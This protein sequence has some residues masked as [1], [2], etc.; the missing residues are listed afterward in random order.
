LPIRNYN[1][2][3]IKPKK[4]EKKKKEEDGEDDNSLY[5]D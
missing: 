1:P 3:L 5:A 2:K 4:E